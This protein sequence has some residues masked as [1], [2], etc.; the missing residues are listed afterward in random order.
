MK[1]LWII[2]A[3][4]AVCAATVLSVNATQHNQFHT[5]FGVSAPWSMTQA[6]RDILQPFVTKELQESKKRVSDAQAV[7]CEE[8]ACAAK[9]LADFQTAQQ[10]L[11]GAVT[12]ASHF[13]F[14]TSL[15]VPKPTCTDG[16]EPA[17]GSCADG[18]TPTIK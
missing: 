17:D 16:R 6:E 8:P 13:D 11:D 18:S 9:K 1:V 12:A 7:V 14:D 5:S 15:P 2:F 4:I 10:S 3:V